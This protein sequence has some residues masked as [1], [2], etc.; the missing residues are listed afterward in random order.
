M[1]NEEKILAILTSMQ[2]QRHSMEDR[3]DST[4]KILTSMQAEI[5]GIREELGDLTEAHEGTRTAVNSLL[6]WSEKVSS[7]EQLRIPK[8]M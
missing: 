7:I 4:E 3:Q 8:I 2:S 6:A 1:N 5:K